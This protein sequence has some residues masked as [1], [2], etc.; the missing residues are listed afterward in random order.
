MV[1]ISTLK[2]FIMYTLTFENLI[3]DQL[4]YSSQGTDADALLSE[5]ERKFSMPSYNGITRLRV[6]EGAGSVFLHNGQMHRCI[7]R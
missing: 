6:I 1:L 2:E 7:I 5:Y 4:V 3:T